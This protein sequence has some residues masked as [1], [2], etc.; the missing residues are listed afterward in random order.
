[1]SIASL[2]RPTM[3]RFAL[4]CALLLLA[5]LVH[6]DWGRD[7][8]RGKDAYDKGRYDDARTLLQAVIAE[9]PKP[10][11]MARVQPRRMEPYLPQLYLGLS[12]AK[13]NDCPGAVAQLSQ[14]ALM[15]ITRQLADAESL[16]SGAVRDCQAQIAASSTPEPTRPV[17]AAPPTTKS[18]SEG[19]AVTPPMP[20]NDRTESP[21]P[22]AAQAAHA[23]APTEPAP[24]DPWVRERNTIRNLLRSYLAGTLQATAIPV[25]ENFASIRAKQ[26]VY[27]LRA[28]LAARTSLV[29]DQD[30]GGLATARRDYASARQLGELPSAW[31]DL[32]SPRVRAAIRDE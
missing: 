23:T 21:A 32:A 27:I 12:L 26:W 2:N 30:T 17:A 3:L 18:S 11:A 22:A 16:R 1:M 13:L 29:D 7:Y 19:S 20:A 10:E 9:N 24:A 5:P 25:P 14:P 8:V 15:S 31:R 4:A 6:A 28:L